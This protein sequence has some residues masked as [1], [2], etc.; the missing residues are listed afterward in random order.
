MYIVETACL[1]KET[2]RVRTESG[3]AV[4][5]LASGDG[6]RRGRGEGKHSKNLAP[7]S[8]PLVH[9]NSQSGFSERQVI[10]FIISW[11]GRRPEREK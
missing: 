2:V 9:S 1:V 8:L 10:Q 11:S 7:L 4:V 6:K 5:L 3:D